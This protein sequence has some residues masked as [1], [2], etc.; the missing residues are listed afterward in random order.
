[1]SSPPAAFLALQNK[2][3]RTYDYE[4][5]LPDPATMMSMTG[6]DYLQAVLRGDMPAAPIAYT[7]NFWPAEFAY[8]RAVFEGDPQRHSYNPLGSVHGGWAATILD[9]ALGCAVH[10]T[11]PVDLSITLVRAITERV[12]R[13]RCEATIVHAGGSVATAQARV[14][15]EAGTLF[16]TGTTT[17]LVLTPR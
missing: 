13:L 1:M 8:G 14:T 2:H 16:A 4:A 15:D 17:C 6:L 12:K 3:T 5:R 7:L 10:T 11:L 9:S